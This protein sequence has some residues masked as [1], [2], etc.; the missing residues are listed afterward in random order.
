MRV[1]TTIASAAM[2]VAMVL[3]SAAPAAATEAR[4][5]RGYIEGIAGRAMNA[6]RAERGLPPLRWNKQLR[7]VAR[8]HSASM[9]RDGVLRHS[10]RLE[11]KVMRFRML[12]ENI[13]VG[14]SMEA[15]HT[16]LMESPG[17]RSNILGG[18]T[19]AGV[20]ATVTEYEIYITQ[21]FVTPAKRS[22]AG[23]R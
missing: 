20:G 2:M 3:G 17:H 15:I 11:R 8:A 13:G 18:Y 6:A 5:T 22:R 10:V 19:I 12:G 16:A 14:F 9:G 21:I 7:A 1:P 4:P 23:A